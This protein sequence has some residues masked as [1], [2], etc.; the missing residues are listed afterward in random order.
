MGLKQ[1]R[2]Y[3]S[4]FI[5]G[6]YI[7]Y[8]SWSSPWILV[9]QGNVL[10]CPVYGVTSNSVKHFFLCLYLPSVPAFSW[11]HLFLTP[12]CPLPPSL[13][14]VAS[15][16]L[17]GFIAVLAFSFLH[18]LAELTLYWLQ[19]WIFQKREKLAKASGRTSYISCTSEAGN[20]IARI[21]GK[22]GGSQVHLLSCTTPGTGGWSFRLVAPWLATAFLNPEK[23]G[24]V[25][26]SVR[27]LLL[28]HLAYSM[29]SSFLKPLFK[30]LHIF[31]S[32]SVSLIDRLL[33]CQLFS[34]DGES[35]LA[36]KHSELSSQLQLC[37]CYWN[38]WNLCQALCWVLLLPNL[39]IVCFWDG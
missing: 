30:V 23:Q 22:V 17:L 36:I 14:S 15:W 34:W 21:S 37:I 29:L 25:M 27:R 4:C 1:D 38:W 11:F 32:M 24:W 31:L 26:S 6:N 8:D 20:W 16:F 7:F 3:W 13:L 9:P 18:R 5:C 35:W 10:T 39:E 33:T 28:R 2:E 12:L 19:T